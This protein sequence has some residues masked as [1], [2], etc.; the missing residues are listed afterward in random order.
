MDDQNVIL[1]KNVLLQLKFDADLEFDFGWNF[2]PV[3]TLGVRTCD[4][5]YAVAFVE[6][7]NPWVFCAFVNI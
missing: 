5:T 4:I 7:L 2:E 3:L 1:V 6:T